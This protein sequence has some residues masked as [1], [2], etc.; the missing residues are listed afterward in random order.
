M[1]D[2][3]QLT[4]EERDRIYAIMTEIH[5]FLNSRHRETPAWLIAQALSFLGVQS[6]VDIGVDLADFTEI[7]TN[8][9][10]SYKRLSEDYTVATLAPGNPSGRVH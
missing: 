9:W 3:R 5:E 2:V 1:S 4:D 10:A 6:Y 7:T 8:F